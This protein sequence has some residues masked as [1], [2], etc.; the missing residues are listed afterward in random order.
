MMTGFGKNSRI[1]T[2]WFNSVLVSLDT[3][4]SSVQ[5]FDIVT[6]IKNKFDFNS[7]AYGL[8][9]Q[10]NFRSEDYYIR[11]DDTDEWKQTYIQ[12]EYWK[13][14]TRIIVARQQIVPFFWSELPHRADF[15]SSDVMMG[16]W[17]GMTVP[18]HGPN[19]FFGFLH[20]TYHPEQKKI[21]SWLQYIQPFIVYLAQHI[22]NAKFDLIRKKSLSSLFCNIWKND[23][24]MLTKQQRKC[25][26]WAAEGKNTEEIALILD[27]SVSTVN[28][29]L[30]AASRMLNANNRSH[31]IAKAVDGN[32]IALEY[33]K[34]STIFFF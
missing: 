31:A 11:S 32:L 9:V 8:V 7:I 5:L 24:K 4:K 23:S 2:K 29:H 21:A 17:D 27:I 19:H 12:M 18:V 6:D 34:K 26:V 22:I 28:K 20:F 1:P 30:N 15:I 3:V 16:I 14:D 25:L 33:R 10:N 13:I